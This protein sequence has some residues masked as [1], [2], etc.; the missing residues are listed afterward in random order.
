[1]NDGLQIPEAGTAISGAFDIPAIL[2]LFVT[3]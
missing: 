3:A 1:M 2:Y